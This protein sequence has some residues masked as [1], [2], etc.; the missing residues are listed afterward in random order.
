MKDDSLSKDGELTVQIDSSGYNDSSILNTL[1]GMA[2]QSFASSA[3]G[4]NCADVSY[5]IEGLSKRDHPEPVR[6]KMNMCVAGHF[7]SP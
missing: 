1:T 2:A 7:A 5:T 4:G 6:E 3:T